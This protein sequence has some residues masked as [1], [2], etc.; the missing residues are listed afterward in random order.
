MII[1]KYILKTYSCVH[2]FI[3]I[4]ISTDVLSISKR[5]YSE[6]QCDFFIHVVSLAIDVFKWYI[7]MAAKTCNRTCV[8]LAVKMGGLDN[9]FTKPSPGASFSWNTHRSRPMQTIRSKAS[10][11]H[12]HMCIKR[13]H[14]KV[15]LRHS[16]CMSGA[17][18]HAIIHAMYSR[19]SILPGQC[20]GDGLW[21]KDYCWCEY[22]EKENQQALEKFS[23]FVPLFGTFLCSIRKASSFR[24][25]RSVKTYL[26][27]LTSKRAH[28]P[29][30]VSKTRMSS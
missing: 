12:W 18:N 17:A 13:L 28:C 6:V 3:L 27:L 7:T 29:G 15:W 9:N 19:F 22:N 30:A 25:C 20:S 21:Q 2:S 24:V 11:V 4:T 5:G 14:V 26:L 23:N 1:S 16:F 10:L 8:T